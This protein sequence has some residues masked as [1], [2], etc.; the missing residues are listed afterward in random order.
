MHSLHVNRPHRRVPALA[1]S[2]P[3]SVSDRARMSIICCA[4]PPLRPHGDSPFDAGVLGDASVVL[5]VARQV[6]HFGE[7]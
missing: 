5:V 6:I 3:A 2:V 1:E 7:L 4:V